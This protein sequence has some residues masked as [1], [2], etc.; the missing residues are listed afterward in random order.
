MVPERTGL[1]FAKQDEEHLAAALARF[2]T[3]S[4]DPQVL[5]EHAAGFGREAFRAKM[6]AFLDGVVADRD[7]EHATL[8][9]A[10][11]AE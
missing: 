7:P 5:R 4:F 10:E 8:P 11:A 9:Y 6:R 2:E 3:L 1:F